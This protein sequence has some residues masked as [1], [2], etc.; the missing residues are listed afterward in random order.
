MDPNHLPPIN[1]L[2]AQEP[3]DLKTKITE[4]SNELIKNNYEGFLRK[5]VNIIYSILKFLK[6]SVISMISMALGREV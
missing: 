5:L 3:K 4:T 2:P 6:N 1:P